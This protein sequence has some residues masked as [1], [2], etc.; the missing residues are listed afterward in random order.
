MFNAATS[1]LRLVERTVSMRQDAP[2]PSATDKQPLPATFSPRTTS[3]A[4]NPPKR[5]GMLKAIAIADSV[6][7]IDPSRT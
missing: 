3:P 1:R 5:R 6:G 4:A 7:E 2:E